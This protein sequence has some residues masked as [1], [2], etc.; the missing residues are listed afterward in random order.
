MNRERNGQSQPC[1]TNC[2]PFFCAITLHSK[3]LVGV[4]IVVVVDAADIYSIV[5]RLAQ[6]F[7]PLVTPP[8]E[9][10]IKCIYFGCACVNERTEKPL[11]EKS[12]YAI[13]RLF[14]KFSISGQETEM[15]RPT[16]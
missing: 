8:E 15:R 12:I 10:S 7:S 11:Q 5:F 2:Q 13:F 14:C 9:T 6:K 16:D 4:I 1:Q 3:S